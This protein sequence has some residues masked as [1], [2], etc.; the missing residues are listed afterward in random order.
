MPRPR[1]KRAVG[2]RPCHTYFKPANVPAATLE[3]VMVTVDELEA[4]RLKDALGLS[5]EDAAKEMGISQP[6]FH[7]LLTSARKKVSDALVNGMAIRIEGGDYHFKEDLP[8]MRKRRRWHGGRGGT[9]EAVC[10]CPSCGHII[11]KK[12][13]QPCS[14]VRCPECNAQMRRE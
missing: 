4:L 1:R 7:R 14:Q 5:Q 12:V 13:G 3:E 6:T 9:G 10:I 8:D 2:F 11:L